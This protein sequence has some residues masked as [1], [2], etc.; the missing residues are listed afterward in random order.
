MMGSHFVS[1]D[2]N[3]YDES[4]VLVIHKGLEGSR[5]LSVVYDEQQLLS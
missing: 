1:V 4:E 2:F 5:R 3:F